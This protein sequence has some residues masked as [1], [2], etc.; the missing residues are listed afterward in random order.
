MFTA[1]I[2][3]QRAYRLEIKR[4][5][6]IPK[7]ILRMRQITKLME[8]VFCH[9]WWNAT[10]RTHWIY[11]PCAWWL[12]LSCYCHQKHDDAHCRAFCREVW[13]FDHK[14]FVQ[15]LVPWSSSIW[16]TC[17]AILLLMLCSS[18]DLHFQPHIRKLLKRGI[19]VSK[20][21]IFQH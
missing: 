14:D 11:F 16:N 8:H 10:T 2:A 1:Q 12:T 20:K 17:M 19:V 9:A 4:W 3:R 21:F 13:L 5:L 18:V 7:V 15:T 6:A